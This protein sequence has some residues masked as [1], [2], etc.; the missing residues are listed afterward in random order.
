[1]V[2]YTQENNKIKISLCNL[3]IIYAQ[4]KTRLTIRYKVNHS[5]NII[6]NVFDTKQ[7]QKIKEAS[8]P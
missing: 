4:S 3:S 6:E 1:M 8:H 7:Q 2:F 5:K